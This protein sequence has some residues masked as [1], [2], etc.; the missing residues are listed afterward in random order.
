MLFRSKWLE[1]H[2]IEHWTHYYTDYGVGLQKRFF[3]YFLKGEKN[4]WDKQPR[5]QLNVRHP[6][7]TFV[8]RHEDAWPIPRT[9]WTKCHL[10]SD[11]QK[12]VTEAP[13]AAGTVT[14]DAKGDGVTF[15]TEPMRAPTE[16][17]GPV[18]AKLQVSSTTED[19]DLFLVLRVFA[20]DMKEVT[21]Q[22]ALDPHTPIGQGWLRVS[23]RELDKT[24][25][26]PHRPYHTHQRKQPLK[27]GEVYEVEIEIVPTCIVV[28]KGYRVGLSIR[29]RD[30]VYPGGSGGKLSNMKNE[31][32]GN[33]P[34]LHDDP[35][36]R[37]MAIYG[38]ETT[39]HLGGGRENF[40]LLPII[41]ERVNVSPTRRGARAAK[42][43]LDEVVAAHHEVEVRKR[44]RRSR[45]KATSARRR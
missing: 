45:V 11:A 18:A 35:R 14:F 24:L 28:P 37:P 34:F 12:L 21:F 26:L 13:K 40:L 30:Y 36:D 20:P 22:G 25:T 7:E 3:G 39:L 27:P 1:V 5:V 32:T 4:G 16:I 41:P 42:V 9:Q 43:M 6:G 33:G 38:G 23:H 19:A 2:G 44:R 15:L 8:I 10:A 17:T 29:G 31:F